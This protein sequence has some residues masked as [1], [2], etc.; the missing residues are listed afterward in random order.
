MAYTTLLQIKD[1]F[2]GISIEPSTGDESVDTAVSTEAIAQFIIDADAEIDSRLNKYY[3]TPIT[4]VESLKLINV[5][6]KYK[7]AHV[8]KTVLEATNE[9][10]DRNQDVQTNLELKANAMLENMIPQCVNG[11]WCDPTAELPD[12]PLKS[13]SPKSAAVFSS[14]TGTATITKGGNNW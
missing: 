12:A 4:G 1:L 13:T 11:T 8:V 10:S 3:V 5:I 9:T 6:S 14:N 7:V 2:R